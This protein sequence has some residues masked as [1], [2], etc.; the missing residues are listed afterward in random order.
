MERYASRDDRHTITQSST[1]S[2]RYDVRTHD[3]R[4]VGAVYYGGRAGYR[5]W[6]DGELT[7]VSSLGRALAHYR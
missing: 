2:N 4:D 3:G 6:R 7:L 5:C 1:H